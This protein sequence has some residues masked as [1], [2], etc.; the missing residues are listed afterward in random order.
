[1]KWR[2]GDLFSPPLGAL[3]QHLTEGHDPARLL[4]VRNNFIQQALG[5]GHGLFGTEIPDRLPE[6]AEPAATDNPTP[7]QIHVEP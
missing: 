3:H 1:V 6:I 4:V 2:E 5:S 7:A